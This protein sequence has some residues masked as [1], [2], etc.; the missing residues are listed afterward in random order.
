MQNFISKWE[1]IE[2]IVYLQRS[3]WRT[4]H[5][6]LWTSAAPMSPAALHRCS[7]PVCHPK[8]LRSK[9]RTN[10][11]VR[12]STSSSQRNFS[13][14]KEHG[15]AQPAYFSDQIVG[16]PVRLKDRPFYGNKDEELTC[17]S[18]HNAESG[19]SLY[20]CARLANCLA[21]VEGVKVSKISVLH[22]RKGYMT[23]V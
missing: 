7:L 3:S 16:F 9:T 18:R 23:D 5:V 17:L 6:L 8:T 11:Q 10:K 20:A 4:C 12:H 21:N 15:K 2:G 22:T 13:P 19:A 1:I 14:A